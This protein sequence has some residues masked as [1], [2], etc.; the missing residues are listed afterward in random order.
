M[1][2]I[3]VFDRVINKKFIRNIYNVI[4]FKKNNLYLF[5]HIISFS[6]VNKPEFVGG[7]TRLNILHFKDSSY[8]L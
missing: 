8:I 5:R 1:H 7:I 6:L 3:A 4:F 2:S